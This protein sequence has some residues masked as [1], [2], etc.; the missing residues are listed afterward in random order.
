M[1]IEHD[2]AEIVSGL[3]KGE[4]LGTPVTLSIKN[5][6]WENWKEVFDP[7]EGREDEGEVTTPRPGHADLAG[8]QKRGFRDARKVLERAS[9]RK[10]AARVAGGALARDFLNQFGVSVVSRVVEIGGVRDGADV[11]E[12]E[13]LSEEADDSPLR[14]LGAEA[15]EKM[16]EE[17]REAEK[18]GDT[19]GGVFEVT[20]LGLPPGIGD[21]TTSKERLDGLLAGA[22]MSIPAIKAVEIGS[23]SEAA[24]SRGSR[25]QDEI[26]YDQDKGGFYRE[27]NRAGGL[28]GG[29]TNGE[30]V[31]LEISMKPIP[32]LS[33]PLSTVDMRTGKVKEAAKERSDVCA[34]PAASVVGEA[35]MGEVICGCWLDK[36]GGDSLSQTKKAYREYEESLE[37]WFEADE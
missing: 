13:N 24:G 4:T 18:K 37:G 23:G 35:V 27:T 1:E 9:A 22:M 34:V 26:F 32:T 33:S 31:R 16:K 19:L 8:S 12:Y 3:Y 21:Y 7:P 15:E 36:F 14:V 25:V 29:V 17:I 2:R 5:E 6:D 28:E 10:T 11:S 20:A 30:P